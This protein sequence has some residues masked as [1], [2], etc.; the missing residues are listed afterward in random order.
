M[1]EQA[2]DEFGTEEELAAPLAPVSASTPSVQTSQ[3]AATSTGAEDL[4]ITVNEKIAAKLG[5][6]GQVESFEVKG[7]M[8]LRI[9]DSSVAQVRVDLDCGDLRGAQLNTHP[10][11]DKTVFKNDKIIQL[12]DTSRGFPISQQI[13]VLR[14]RTASKTDDGTE[15]PIKFTAWVNEGSPGMFTVTVEY[16][17]S[18]SDALSG[19]ELA[20]PF[21][22][23]EPTVTSS[24]AEYDL[25]AGSLVWKIGDVHDG[26]SSGS[27][28]FEAQAAND[29]DFFPMDVRFSKTKP[30]VEVDVSLHSW[31]HAR[32]LTGSLGIY[33]HSHQHGSIVGFHKGDQL[34]CRWISRCLEDVQY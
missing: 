22:G 31:F 30:Y 10:K 25:E 14:W 15:V 4:H 9:S 32:L 28:D 19:V 7:D 18:G 34:G 11:V 1:F 17:L 2:R 33:S 6:E 26:A 5:R 27:F 12:Q 13:E 8:K 29:A 21:N 24:D 23:D 3:A 16:E 20:I